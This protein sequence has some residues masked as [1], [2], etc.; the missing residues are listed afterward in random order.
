VDTAIVGSLLTLLGF[1]PGEQVYNQQRPNGH[2]DFAP[3][4]TVYGTCFIVE[5]KSTSLQ[6]DFDLTN[7]ESHLS[8]LLGYMRSSGVYLGWLTNGKQLTV[9]SF[10]K[11]NKPIRV[12]N[13]DIPEIIFTWKSQNPPVLSSSIEEALYNLFDLCRKE[14]FADTKRLEQEIAISQE[15]WQAKAL[16]LGT[17]SGNEAVLVETLQSLVAEL[18][19]DAKRTLDGHLKRYDD[20]ADRINRL[21]DDAAELATQQLKSLRSRMRVILTDNFQAIWGLEADDLLAIEDI[22]TKAEQDVR[23]FSSP[24]EVNVAL[25]VI[26]NAARQRK[27]ATKPKARQPM[28]DFTEV[29]I[30]HDIVHTY[31]E[32]IFT[33]HQR[34]ALLRHDYRTDRLIQEDYANWTS[35]VKETSLGGLDEDRRRDE[36]AL[37]AAYVVFIRLLLI[38]VCEDK[39]IF[40]HRFLSD[41]GIRHWQEDIER[42][43]I[44]AQGNPYEPLLDLAYKNAQNIYAHFFTGRELFN[45]FK[46]DRQRFVMTLHRLSRFNFADVD[47]DIIGTVYNTYVNRKEKRDKGQYYTPSEIIHYIL[48]GVDYNGKNVIGSNKRLIDP[49]CGSG[50]F[51]VAAAK[52]LV[53]AYKG[54]A[55]QIEDPA[56]L[57]GRVK[58]NLFGFDINP[59]ACYLAEVNLLIQVLDLIKLAH[60]KGQRPHLERFNIYN[61]DALTPPTGIAYY[62]YFNTL[63]AA[64]NDQVDQI[65]SRAQDTPYE[66]GFAFVVANPPYGASVSDSYKEMLRNNWADVFFGQPD[67]YTFF[68]RLGIDLLAKSGKFGFIT[69]NT[70]LT[71]KNTMPLRN[72]LLT[73]GRI[74]QIV[75]LP[76]GIWKDA[77]VDCVL[78]FFTAETNEEKRRVQQVQIHTLN[79]QDKLD[80]LTNRDWAESFIHQ[81]SHWSANPNYEIT[82]RR[83]ALLQQIEKACHV[84]VNNGSTTKVLHLNDITKRSQ[85]IIIYETR[86]ERKANLYIRPYRDIP[87]EEHDWKPLL[88]GSGFIGRYELRQN[89]ERPYLKYGSWLCRPRDPKYFE[90]PKLLLVRLRNK[91]LRRKLVATYDE[92][93]FFNSDNYNNIIA[94]DKAYQLKYVLALFNSSLLNYWYGRNFDNVNINPATFSLLPIYPADQG[95]QEILARL[96]DN[97]LEKNVILNKLRAEGYG[98]KQR[99]DGTASINAPYDKLLRELQ[100]VDRNFPVLTLF[101]AK[102]IRLFNIPSQCDLQSQVSGNVYVPSRYPTSLVLRH[103][104]LWLEIPDDTIRRYLL[105]YLS[106]PQWQGKTWDEIKNVALI[107]EDMAALHTFFAAEERKIHFIADLLADIKRVDAEIDE[108]VLDLYDITD[109]EDRRRILGSAPLEEEEEIS[110]EEETEEIFPDDI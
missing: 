97:I 52:R 87:P 40:P 48:D 86:A 16:P 70:Y 99:R 92:S 110:S 95:A 66:Q 28:A 10:D 68:L 85:G 38:R 35:L 27:Y 56:A 12:I 3:M 43:W 106:C 67:T 77:N 78:F 74:E 20:Y 44:F 17:G 100:T 79:L 55:Q 84:S 65:K 93:G 53:S 32:K 41:G 42:Y 11:L 51:L 50:S 2:P 14:V 25:L 13:V 33:W 29:P 82:I 69:P 31:T 7:P 6:L 30:L 75:D 102:A 64:E 22:L 83:D 62:S 34:Q 57:L 36:F 5:D 89:K 45:W 61:V 15:E 104:K 49:S 4:D 90:D 18:Q 94:D 80:K 54:D 103:N 19:A 47:S 60:E 109:E 46:L 37:Q 39:G 23:A 73:M 81:Q 71:G 105:G 108:R 21:S 26:I 107:P 96:V 101:D 9:W 91:S 63:L 24:K 8:Q 1:A 98:I 88:D 76:R 58:D 59:F 72:K